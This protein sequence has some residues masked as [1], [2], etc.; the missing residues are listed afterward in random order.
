MIILRQR[1]FA[2]TN[3]NTNKPSIPDARSN[4]FKQQYIASGGKD[5]TG[6]SLGQFAAANGGKIIDGNNK[7]S[8]RNYNLP[9]GVDNKTNKGM[10]QIAK[11]SWNSMSKNQRR[12]VGAAAGL[13]ALVTGASLL[14]NHKKRKEAEEDLR[15]EK[16]KNRK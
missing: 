8:N 7:N 13:T 3:I 6:M 4:N 14:R 1:S 5:Y 11:D 16:A 10:G 9:F 12:T 15:L 2:N